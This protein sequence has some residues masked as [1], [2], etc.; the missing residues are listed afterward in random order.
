MPAVDCRPRP[1]S[2]H[3]RLAGWLYG[4]AFFG[5]AALLDRRLCRAGPVAAARRCRGRLLR[6]PSGRC[7]RALQRFRA[8]P[9]WVGAVGTAGG[10]TRPPTLRRV[11]WGR[12]AF[13]QA[14]SP[15][16]WFIAFGGAPLVSFVVALGG[17]WSGVRRPWLRRTRFSWSR[18]SPA[19]VAA[20]L[21]VPIVAGAEL[22]ARRA[23]TGRR[24]DHGRPRPGQRPRRR[25]RL[26]GPRPPGARQPRRA[27]DDT[28]G[29]DQ[30]G[31]LAASPS[32]VVWPGD[33]SDIDP[34]AG[35][36]PPTTEIDSAVGAVGVP[37]SGRRHSARPRPDHRRNVGIL[38]S[39][40]ERWGAGRR[41]TPSGT[42]CRSASTSHCAVRSP[43]WSAPTSIWSPRTWSRASGNGVLRGGPFPI[44][45]VICFEVAYDEI[46]WCARR[47]EAGARPCVVQTNN[48]TFGR[49]AETYQ[50]LAMSQLRAVET[51]RT[52][53]Q[54]STTGMIAVIDPDGPSGLAR[55]PL[56]TPAI[57]DSHGALRSDRPRPRDWAPIP[58]Y[59][60]AGARS[61]RAAGPPGR[62]ADP[63][64]ADSDR[65]SAPARP[66]RKRRSPRESAQRV[67][68]VVPTY[69]ERDNVERITE[70]CSAATPSLTCSSSTMAVPTVRARSPTGWR[71]RSPRP[72][73]AP[74]GQV[75][76]RHRLYRRLRLGPGQWASTSSS[77]WMP[78]AP[79]A[80]ATVAPARRAR[81]GRSGPRLS[82]GAGRQLVDWPRRARRSR[83][84]QPLHPPG[85]GYRRA[86]CDRRLSRL[87]ARGSGDDRLRRDRVVAGVLLPGRSGLA[88]GAGGLSGRRG[89]DHLRRT[90][91]GRPKMAARSCVR[92]CS[93]SP[94]GASRHRA[95]QLRGSRPPG[96]VKAPRPPDG[97]TGC[98]APCP[99]STPAA[100]RSSYRAGTAGRR[101]ARPAPLRG[102]R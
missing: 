79:I 18:P 15:V 6:R 71:A 17:G 4:L 12:L 97:R 76:P 88:H 99:S 28:G 69:N 61:A 64:R 36:G 70:R 26:R 95:A 67:L 74:H 78:T 35:P 93:G 45:D 16:R 21:V 94:G 9:V 82:L 81:V 46:V 42:R 1:A 63:R 10:V 52:V 54:V 68:V 55:L 57:I 47:C 91:A 51:G 77:R 3:R 102:R 49:T 30:V 27:D 39:P 53:V 40:D 100:T 90:R 56:F 24:P 73:A 31:H 20:A 87:P 101:A 8:A 2:S 65:D 80:R 34:F 11:P 37:D 22:A 23:S 92:P 43:R 62:S 32:L 13:S 72:R 98:L 50:Q 75:R 48:A 5:T 38:W 25:A 86:R 83:G 60:L 84:V 14:G 19:G 44:G 29:R 33:S 58:E 7:S 66:I 59:L 96:P 89:A 85:P 41:S